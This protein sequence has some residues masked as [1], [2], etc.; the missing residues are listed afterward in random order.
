MA[1]VAAAARRRM[2]R[3]GAAVRAFRPSHLITLTL[4]VVL[5]SAGGAG[6]ATG[7]SFILGKAN[8][9]TSMATLS[10]SKG[11]PLSLSAPSGKAPSRSTAAP[12]S[13]I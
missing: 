6:A 9:E 7:G 5:G 12:W 4:A 10:N 8:T 11:I 3:A 2:R 13:R 1:S